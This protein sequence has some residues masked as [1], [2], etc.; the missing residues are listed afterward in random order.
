MKRTVDVGV[1]HGLDVSVCG[2]MASHPL[3]AFALIGLGV[4][5]LSV[6]PRA[7]PLVKRLVR[8][9]NLSFATEAAVAAIQARTAPEAERQ[10]KV[11]LLAAFGDAAFLRDSVG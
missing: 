5:S 7:V 8:G 2:E 11:R 6:N 9:L 10:L 3:M 4:R 1:A